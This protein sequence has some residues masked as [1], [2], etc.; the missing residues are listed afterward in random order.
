M[1]KRKRVWLYVYKRQIHHISEENDESP[2]AN[3]T[4]EMLP[5][6]NQD[7]AWQMRKAFLY[8]NFKRWTEKNKTD[9]KNSYPN[10]TDNTV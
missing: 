2:L 10:Q 6:K 9:N 7:K 4:L 1:R 5:I 3:S 8:T